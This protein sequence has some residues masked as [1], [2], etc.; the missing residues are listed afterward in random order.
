MYAGNWPSLL[1]LDDRAT[2]A[3]GRFEGKRR[4]KRVGCSR[5]SQVGHNLLAYEP[6]RGKCFFILQSWKLDSKN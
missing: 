2:V 6:N 4:R 3:A 5:A 1:Y